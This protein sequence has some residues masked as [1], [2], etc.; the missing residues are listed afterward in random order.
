MDIID[1][2]DKMNAE[3]KQT[4]MTQEEAD[5]L[6]YQE[7]DCISD[8]VDSEQARIERWIEDNNIIIE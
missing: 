3:P 6:F 8:D 7:H 1:V 2:V 5:E 4:K